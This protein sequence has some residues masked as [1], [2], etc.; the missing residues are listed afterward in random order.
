MHREEL[1]N[2]LIDALKAQGFKIN[3]HV[4]PTTQNKFT[5]RYLQQTSRLEQISFHKK[6]LKANA[7]KVKEFLLNINNF[8]PHNIDLE[9]REVKPDSIEELIFKWWNLV[10]WSVPYQRAYGR[11]MRFVLWDIGHN[12]PFGLI[13]LQSPVLKMAV[14]DNYLNIPKDELDLWVNKSMQAQRLGA[15]PPYN[16]LIGGKMTALAMTSNELRKCYREKYKNYKTEIQGRI[17]E[18]E[19]LF[20]TTT[21][22]FGKSSIYNR[23]KYKNQPVAKSLG[24]TKGAGSFHI[25][26]NLY[27]EIREFL[28][29]NGVN[30]STTFG[31]GPSRKIKLLYTA[32]RL[33]KVPD[34]SYHN[35][36]RE[37]F[38]FPL[39]SNLQDIIQKKETPIYYNRPL[40]DLVDFWKERWCLPRAERKEEWKRYKGEFFFNQLL[41]KH[42]LN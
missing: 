22:A 11:Q 13:G 34:Y 29:D 36:K 31:N 2:R 27:K 12:A 9:L 7:K 4:Q 20:I 30:V 26:E 16:Y 39:A 24:Y 40:K 33:L 32:F 17:I 10:W 21:S 19:L 5:Y 6:F 18:P 14:R 25:P 28:K 15:L 38:L 41:Q 37:F 42:D 35:L 1:K 8:N 23:L 3:P